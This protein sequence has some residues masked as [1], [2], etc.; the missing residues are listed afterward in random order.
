MTD[1]DRPI[2]PRWPHLM[3]SEML[4]GSPMPGEGLCL[5]SSTPALATTRT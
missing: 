2:A 3:E 5:A 1:L 4:K